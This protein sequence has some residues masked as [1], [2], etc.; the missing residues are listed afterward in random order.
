MWIDSE[1]GA[2]WA[3]FEAQESAALA[4]YAYEPWLAV[5]WCLNNAWIDA[6]PASALGRCQALEQG[7][8][9]LQS[10]FALTSWNMLKHFPHTLSVEPVAR[11][12]SRDKN[13]WDYKNDTST[14]DRY[15]KRIFFVELC[16][17]AVRCLKFSLVGA[18]TATSSPLHVRKSWQR[19]EMWRLRLLEMQLWRNDW[20]Q[21]ADFGL[22]SI[23][24]R[25]VDLIWSN[26]IAVAKIC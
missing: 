9:A 24:I 25:L 18:Q 7:S 8:L 21:T 4:K 10:M 22:S 14:R 2:Q 26:C 23:W 3:V 17:M 1:L 11:S 12:S 5:R 6:V 16:S 15:G 13:G 20:A 19:V